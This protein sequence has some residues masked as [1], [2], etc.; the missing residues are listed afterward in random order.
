MRKFSRGDRRRWLAAHGDD[1]VF[2]APSVAI[3]REVFGS[4]SPRARIQYR[5]IALGNHYSFAVAV[6]KTAAS[7]HG[8][9]DFHDTHLVFAVPTTPPRRQW[10]R[11]VKFVQRSR[12]ETEEI[13]GIR[14]ATQAQTV[15]DIARLSS[16]PDAL[17]ACDLARSRGI[18]IT[19][20]QHPLRGTRQA[21][22]ALI[23][24][25]D[26]SISPAVSRARATLIDAHFKRIEV[27]STIYIGQPARP[28]IV[29][30]CINERIAIFD[31]ALCDPEII[32]E[33]GNAGFKTIV[34]TSEDIATGRFL[35]EA[36][37][38]RRK[39]LSEGFDIFAHG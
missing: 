1:F 36:E 37:R 3:E 28:V 32:A 15:L 27:A 33:F 34:V 7:L 23:L 20:P 38:L 17:A 31:R 6:D 39:L 12:I 13:F 30:L 11:G 8:W 10:P 16:F 2:L 14:T 9:P 35:R 24:A 29:P 21:R 18:D 19:I 25:T 22:R 26:A 4:L 5:A